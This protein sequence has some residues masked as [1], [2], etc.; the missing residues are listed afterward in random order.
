MTIALTVDSNRIRSLRRQEDHLAGRSCH[1]VYT[2]IES[3]ERRQRVI[4]WAEMPYADFE[5]FLVVLGD[6]ALEAAEL[7]AVHCRRPFGA[8]A[9]LLSDP[10][11]RQVT[12]SL[13]EAVLPHSTNA[14]EICSLIMP[15][16]S[17]RNG[18][19]T[20]GLRKFVS[21][22][23]ELRGYR[24][25]TLEPSM[26]IV[27]ADLSDC[28]YSGLGIS[29]GALATDVCLAR[30]GVDVLHFTLPTGSDWI[31]EQIAIAKGLQIESSEGRP[32]HDIIAA[33]Q[34]RREFAGTLVSPKSTLEQLISQLY[35]ELLGGI[36]DEIVSRLPL[37]TKNR[38]WRDS[39][40][41]ACAGEATWIPGFGELLQSQLRSR[42]MPLTIDQILL[43]DDANYAV[44]RGGL[45]AA[46][47][48]SD[49]GTSLQPAVA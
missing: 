25:M 43:G 20:D 42:K 5:D 28:A 23:V 40:N 31:D 21:R 19:S 2:A 45:I 33:A 18:R 4:D 3:S 47:L 9:S 44:A 14:D 27:L 17:S 22:L 1:A 8:Q 37:A 7:F 29:F 34:C 24:V 41:V 13:V 11:G 38:A 36:I 16:L 6:R 49:P 35:S 10:I 15:T 32:S 12:S 39:I 46:E 30:H 48:H 26:A